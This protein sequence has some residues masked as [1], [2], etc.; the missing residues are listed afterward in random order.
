VLIERNNCGGQVIDAL[1]YKHAYDKLITYSSREVTVANAAPWT[2]AA[3]VGIYSTNQL[4]T[5]AIMN[6][7]YWTNSLQALRVNSSTTISQLET[8][9]RHPNGAFRKKTD[10]F[11]DDHVLGLVWALF[12]LEPG[13][14]QQ[15]FTI[16]ESD[17]QGKPSVITPNGIY[18]TNSLYYKLHELDESIPLEMLPDVHVK[19][20][21]EE[22]KTEIRKAVEQ[23]VTELERLHR[24]EEEYDLDYLTAEG[25]EIFQPY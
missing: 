3:S 8:F 1:F 7:R 25:Y 21:V 23:H 19:D 18:E 14:C 9:V 22:E 17:D 10:T 5:S 20:T 15:Y 6:L 16:D 4:R 24:E 13:I 2:K 11:F 12:I